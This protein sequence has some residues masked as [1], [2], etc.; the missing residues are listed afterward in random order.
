MNLMVIHYCRLFPW[1]N[2]LMPRNQHYMNIWQGVFPT[3]NTGE[4]GYVGTAPV[5]VIVVW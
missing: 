2:K 5:R 1:G 3:N 4:D